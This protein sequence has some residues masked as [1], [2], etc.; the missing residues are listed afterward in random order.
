ML[1]KQIAAQDQGTR[2]E[3]GGHDL[4][5]DRLIGQVRQQEAVLTRRSLP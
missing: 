4:R 5:G 1:V 2:A 3:L